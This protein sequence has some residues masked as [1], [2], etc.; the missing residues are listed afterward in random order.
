MQYALIFYDVQLILAPMGVGVGVGKASNH[1]AFFPL[2][3]APSHP[4]E[5]ERKKPTLW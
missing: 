5:G 4:G 1:A 3:L 2:P